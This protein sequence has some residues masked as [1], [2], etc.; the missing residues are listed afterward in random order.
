VLQWSQN[1]ILRQRRIFSL[2]I[3]RLYGR[4]FTGPTTTNNFVSAVMDVLKT[5]SS[6]LEIFPKTASQSANQS[7]NQVSHQA[8]TYNRW[9]QFS[10]LSRIERKY[11]IHTNAHTIIA[12]LVTLQDT[13]TGCF[14]IHTG[15]IHIRLLL[16]FLHC[17]LPFRWRSPDLGSSLRAFDSSERFRTIL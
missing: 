14:W 4:F 15:L 9:Q 2:A 1:H 13:F 12:N 7:I 16:S 17:K 5:S 6:K 11:C 8:L 3:A 10:E